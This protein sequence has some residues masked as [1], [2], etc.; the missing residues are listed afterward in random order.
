V[1]VSWIIPRVL[2]K[3]RINIMKDKID[4]WDKGLHGLITQLE[5]IQNI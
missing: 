1:N 4:L 3:E 5:G 2:D